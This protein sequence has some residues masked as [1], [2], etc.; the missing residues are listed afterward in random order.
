MPAGLGCR[1][2]IELQRNR[3][4]DCVYQAPVITHAPAGFAAITPP[5]SM[6]A[7]HHTILLGHNGTAPAFIPGGRVPPNFRAVLPTANTPAATRKGAKAATFVAPTNANAVSP[8]SA[9]AHPSG[10]V[11]VP[12]TAAQSPLGSNAG[13]GPW[14]RG[15]HGWRRNG[16]YG[17][18]IPLGYAFGGPGRA[19]VGSPCRRSRATLI[20]PI[21]NRTGRPSGRPFLAVSEWRSRA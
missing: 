2:R 13:V 15:Q 7:Q 19:S 10:H 9:M 11:F 16:G 3:S 8:R 1:E 12:P 17:H 21:R 6:T 18:V 14:W 5:A 20:G 4:D